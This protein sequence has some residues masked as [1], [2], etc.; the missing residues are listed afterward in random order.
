METE[1]EIL[2]AM[3]IIILVIIILIRETGESNYKC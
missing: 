1:M 3:E 2:I